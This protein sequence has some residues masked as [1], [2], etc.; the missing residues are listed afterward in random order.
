[1]NLKAM[2]LGKVRS[3]DH[4]QHAIVLHR[5]TALVNQAEADVDIHSQSS[6]PRQTNKRVVNI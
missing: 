3:N 4:V 1:M 6:R 2:R 5:N